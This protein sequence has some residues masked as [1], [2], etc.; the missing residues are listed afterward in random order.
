MLKRKIERAWATPAVMKA[1]AARTGEGGS[2]A[3]RERPSTGSGLAA[4]RRWRRR[5]ERIGQQHGL[6]VVATWE[7]CSGGVAEE[8]DGL[9]TR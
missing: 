8:I 2:G 3:G 9:V 4:R 5:A 1:A 7:R 6:F